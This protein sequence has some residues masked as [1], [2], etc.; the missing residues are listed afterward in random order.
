MGRSHQKL[1]TR[2]KSLES[3]LSHRLIININFWII[4][5]FALASWMQR[6][7]KLATD[8]MLRCD[9]AKKVQFFQLYLRS[10]RRFHLH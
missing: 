2:K 3:L 4:A 10:F 9:V 6:Q 1:L 8:W 7:E 5:S